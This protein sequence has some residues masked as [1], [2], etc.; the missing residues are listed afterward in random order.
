MANQVD[1][2]H[3]LPKLFGLARESTV[4]TV[5]DPNKQQTHTGR[6]CMWFCKAVHGVW[7]AAAVS[8]LSER[9]H[10][11]GLAASLAGSLPKKAGQAL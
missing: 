3:L 5:L 9:F 8:S 1:P 11:T 7:A 10:C 4:D 2:V 6:L